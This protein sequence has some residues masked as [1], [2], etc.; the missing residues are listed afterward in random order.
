MNRTAT[1]TADDHSGDWREQHQRWDRL[2]WVRVAVILAALVLAL[3][4]VAA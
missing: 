3:V 1:W 2:H 4:A